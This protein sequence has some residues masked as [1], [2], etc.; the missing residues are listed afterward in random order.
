MTR[1]EKIDPSCIEGVSRTMFISLKHRAYGSIS[2]AGSYHD[3]VAED[4]L[5]SIEYPW[6]SIR[7][8][9]S[10]WGVVVRTELLDDIARGFVKSNPDGVVINIGAGLCTR[11][12]RLQPDIRKWVEVDFPS[13]ISFR[14]LLGEPECE[15]HVFIPGSVTEKGTISRLSEFSDSPCLFIAEGLLV[16][17]SES[18]NK[19]LLN[20]ISSSFGS[21]DFFFESI[22]PPLMLYKNF[23]HRSGFGWGCWSGRSIESWSRDMSFAGEIP[24]GGRHPELLDPARRLLFQLPFFRSLLRIIHVKSKYHGQIR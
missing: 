7:H 18:D 2:K 11:F 3:P 13:V 22:T 24:Y 8:S 14:R 12:H 10:Y 19:G 1:H 4:F 16:Y 17:L 5:N 15:K 21:F 9:P 6:D 20:N 23:F